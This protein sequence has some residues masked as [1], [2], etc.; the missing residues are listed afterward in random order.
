VGG[1]MDT[2]FLGKCIVDKKL[3]YNMIKK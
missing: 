2:D 3:T 1:V